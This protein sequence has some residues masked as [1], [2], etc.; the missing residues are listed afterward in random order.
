[1][2]KADEPY[3]LKPGEV[4]FTPG[5][6]NVTNPN[7]AL[8]HESTLAKL[9]RE[10]KA[11][12]ADSP[13][14]AAYDNAIRKASEVTAQITEPSQP[15]V[16]VVTRDG[17]GVEFVSRADAVGRRPAAVDPES[18]AALATARGQAKLAIGLPQARL[19]VASMTQNMDRL[20]DAMTELHDDKGLSNITGTL[21]GRTPNVTNVAT[22]A[23]AKLNSIKSQIFQSSLQAMREASKTGGAVGNVS[24]REGDKLE[25]TLAALDQAQGTDDFKAQLKKAIAQVKLSKE[26]IQNAF[27]EQFGDASD[28]SGPERRRIDEPPPGAVRPR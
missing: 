3:T 28:Y 2:K 4:R 20:T 8:E 15:P 26:L 6:A 7:P 18:Q 21:F 19:R 5:Q 24:D 23:Q 9:V 11:L 10:K 17:K 16:A 1:M 22:G 14:H 27:D 25:R 12:P 13:L